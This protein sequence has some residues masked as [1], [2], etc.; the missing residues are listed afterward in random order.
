MEG[1]NALARP[2]S[3]SD[4]ALAG[5]RE[6][7]A[8]CLSLAAGDVLALFWDGSTRQTARVLNQAAQDLQLKVRERFV[9]VREQLALGG[10]LSSEDH[11]ALESARGILT[12]LSSNPKATAY[13]RELLNVGPNF[14]NFFGHM[15]GATLA[16]LTHA[17]NVDHAA[18]ERRCDDLALAFSVSRS[19][20][21]VTYDFDRYGK[22]WTQHKLHLEF[23]GPWAFPNQQHRH[24]PKG[25]GATYPVARCPS[26]RWKRGRTA[27]SRSMAPLKS[28]SCRTTRLFIWS[29]TGG[30]WSRIAGRGKYRKAFEALLASVRR[31][32]NANYNA[33]AELG[34]GVNAGLTELTG[35][36]LFDEK[37]AGTAHVAIGDNERYGGGTRP[38]RMRTS[39]PGGLRSHSMGSPCSPSARTPWTRGFSR[40]HR[41]SAGPRF[42]DRTRRLVRS[43]R[44]SDHRTTADGCLRVP[45]CR[46]GA[47]LPIYRGRAG[48]QP[49][50][51]LSQLFPGKAPE[52]LRRAER[53]LGVPRDR[54]ARAIEIL[55]RHHIIYRPSEA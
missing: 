32:G 26:R 11:A 38:K 55:I 20:V 44:R 21:L 9:P 17:A 40:I 46:R 31:R 43:Q 25:P 14:D 28:T 13:R 30:T 52:I 27:F 37:C 10:R 19:A 6:L 3:Q 53:D 1:G 22:P 50:V 49:D 34:V 48:H 5:A 42:S 2:K 7:L 18:A 16:V 35:T 47:D 29:S 4:L 39:L 36:A 45:F 8:T 54:V 12:C 23:V 41:R 51:V 15:P 33:L 24:H